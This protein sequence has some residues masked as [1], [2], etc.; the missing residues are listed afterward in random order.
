M[1]NAIHISTARAILNAGD[2]VDLDLWKADGS[3]LQLR[4][5]ISLG[6]DF[7]GGWRN[8]K[9]LSSGQKRRIRDVCIFRVN[10]LEVFL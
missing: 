10:G 3:I 8:I 6:Y 9:I 7:Y 4:S 5:V 2:P 1:P